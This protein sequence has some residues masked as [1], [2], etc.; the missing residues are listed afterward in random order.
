MHA[1]LFQ[2]SNDS[3]TEGDSGS[4]SP[5][6]IVTAAHLFEHDAAGWCSVCACHC[7]FE[8]SLSPHIPS[9]V[10]TRWNVVRIAVA[11]RTRLCAFI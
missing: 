1:F 10:E 8:V 3:G 6:E 2:F 4:L 5:K 9:P 7:V 11:K